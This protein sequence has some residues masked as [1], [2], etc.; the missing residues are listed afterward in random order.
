MID[1]K[2]FRLDNKMT[3]KDAAKYFGVSQAFISQIEKGVRPVP[4]DFI[5]KIKA[6]KNFLIIEHGAA[7]N[8]GDENAE[9]ITISKQAWELIQKQA[10]IILSQQSDSS[11]LIRTIENLSLYAVGKQDIADNAHSARAES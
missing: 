11:S 9:I 6:D 10:Q 8:Y 7:M 5:S 4:D 1:F 2:R 3:Q